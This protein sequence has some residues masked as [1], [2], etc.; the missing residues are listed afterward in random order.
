MSTFGFA[1][2]K[3]RTWR[4]RTVY[5]SNVYH[6][7]NLNDTIDFAAALLTLRDIERPMFSSEVTFVQ[8]RAWGP[9]GEGQAAS[10]T[11]SIVDWSV[12]GTGTNDA[13]LYKETALLIQWPLGRY[14]SR[15]HPQFL[16]K[17]LH[18]GN[19]QSYP[20][21]GSGA[22]ASDSAPMIA[23]KDAL[24]APPVGSQLASAILSTETGRV[25][26]SGGV[27]YPYLE[28]RQYER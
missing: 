22:K 1:I 28:H 6:F 12:A 16:R 7:S 24:G 11:K 3:K 18:T 21:D 25:A 5:F 17:W 20:L 15:N 8:G 4:G 14:G 2:K 26:Q 27:W 23:Y 9:T 19:A 10:V 13:S